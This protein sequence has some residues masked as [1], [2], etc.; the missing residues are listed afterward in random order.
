MHREPFHRRLRK[1]RALRSWSQHEL[2]RRAGIP[3]SQL[4]HY[5]LGTRQA[6]DDHVARLAA[7]LRV[8]PEALA[9]TPAPPPRKGGWP[10][11]KLSTLWER[12]TPHPRRY[13]LDREREN[14]VRLLA[15]R[16]TYPLLYP[17]YLGRVLTL[18]GRQ[19]FTE[20]LHYACCGSG[21]EM[22]AWLRILDFAMISY[23]SLAR[24]GWRRMAV[25]EYPSGD[26]VG[27][28]LW[29]VLVFKEPFLCALFPQVRVRTPIQD[30][31]MDLLA[32]IRVGDRLV[33]LN[34]EIDGPEHDSEYDLTREAAIG[35]PRVKVTR[36]DIRA[37]D[38]KRRFLQKLADAAEVDLAA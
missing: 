31:R 16:K 20:L 4:A 37:R 38:F 13:R 10:A 11:W 21:L 35:L 14:W 9:P 27:D 28:R 5:E 3:R 36:E 26:V 19:A 32:C 23:V 24:L 17:L 8:A 25:L 33:W 30:Y 18:H 29:P 6:S 12:F 22:M 7:A 34:V 2:A 15:A 1:R